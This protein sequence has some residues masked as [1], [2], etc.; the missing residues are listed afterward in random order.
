MSKKIIILGVDGYIGNALLQKLLFDKNNNYYII[1]ID[2]FSRRNL[3]KSIDGFSAISIMDNVDKVKKLN[4]YFNKK[5][6]EFHQLDLIKD[7]SKIKDLIKKHV[8]DNIINL[9]H[10]PSAAYSMIS[11]I[12]AENTL[13]NNILPTNSLL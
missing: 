2:N 4:S 10:Q 1:G 5:K 11:Q 8:P 6:Y 7:I 9:A 3:V 12:D 13:S